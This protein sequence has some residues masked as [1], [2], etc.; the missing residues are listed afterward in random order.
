MDKIN[1]YPK[2]MDTEELLIR[3]VTRI[4]NLSV[5]LGYKLEDEKRRLTR[6]EA[7]QQVSHI[8]SLSKRILDDMKIVK[9]LDN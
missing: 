9:G 8:V 2:K 1:V 6:E 5:A 7:Y 4:A 3:E